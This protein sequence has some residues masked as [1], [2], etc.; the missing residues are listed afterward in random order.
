[1]KAKETTKYENL[2]KKRFI[3]NN[4]L[5]CPEK[6]ELSTK[7]IEKFH[8]HLQKSYC[9]SNSLSRVCRKTTKARLIRENKINSSIH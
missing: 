6:H 9:H 8:A 5:Q 4:Q 3:L 2:K 1:M 7:I